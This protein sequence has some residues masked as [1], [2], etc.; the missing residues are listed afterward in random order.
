MVM[1]TLREAY[2]ASLL[3]G[4]MG[5]HDDGHLQDPH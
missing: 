3:I 4:D 1:L 5:M 2:D